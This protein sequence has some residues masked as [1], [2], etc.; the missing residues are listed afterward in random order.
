M[1]FI[2]NHRNKLLESPKKVPT[3]PHHLVILWEDVHVDDGWGGSNKHQYARVYVFKDEAEWEKA[4]KE[5]AL[6]EGE[7]YPK[8][9]PMFMAYKNAH[10][11]LIAV[12]A[13][14]TIG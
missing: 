14:V 5:L 6:D 2:Y 3:T 11:A 4:V 10:P 9:K 8:R 7:G 1:D 12:R 13:D